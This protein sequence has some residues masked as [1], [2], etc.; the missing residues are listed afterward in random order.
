MLFS[1]SQQQWVDSVYTS[2][3]L[4]Q[5]IGQLFMVMAYPDGNTLKQ[6]QTLQSIR[7]QHVGG[8]LFSKGTSNHIDF[9]LGIPKFALPM[10]V[11]YVGVLIHSKSMGI[12][13]VALVGVLGFAFRNLVFGWIEKIYQHEKHQTLQ[14]YKQK[15]A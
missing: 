2:M 3:T 14:A 12:A 11:F 10:F 1:Q 9:L 4:D 5:K 7:N 6:N 15:N 8:V 13:M